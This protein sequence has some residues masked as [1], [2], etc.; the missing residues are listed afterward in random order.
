M[1]HFAYAQCDYMVILNI[2]K[3]PK[4][5]WDTSASVSVTEKIINQG[6]FGSP[7][8]NGVKEYAFTSLAF[9]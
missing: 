4:L 1:G 2:V 9:S 6:E 7:C 3:N 8:G 5:K